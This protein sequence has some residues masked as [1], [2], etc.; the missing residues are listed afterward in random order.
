VLSMAL[1]F[2]IQSLLGFDFVLRGRASG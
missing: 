2:A 1:I